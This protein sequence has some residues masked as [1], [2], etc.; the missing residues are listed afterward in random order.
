M[1]EA[2]QPLPLERISPYRLISEIGHG[3]MGTVYLAERDGDF[4][5]RVAI[6]VVRGLLGAD[7]LRRFR[8]E[9][10]ILASLIRRCRRR[11]WGT[12]GFCFNAI[13]AL[14][15]SRSCARRSLNARNSCPSGTG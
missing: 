6:K 5:Q 1:T 13:G 8:A 15:P 4:H 10:Q 14:T 11:G 9:R 12:A 2:T 3:G 7:G